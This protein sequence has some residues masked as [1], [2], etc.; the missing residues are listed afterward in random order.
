MTAYISV[1]DAQDY[2]DERLNTSAWD[3]HSVSGDNSQEKALKQATRIINRLNFIGDKTD[4]AQENQFPRGGD[5][6]IP[7]DIEI[8]C[9]EIAIALLDGV[10]PEIEL[11][12]LNMKTSAYGQTK[13]DYDRTNP[14][15]HIIAGVP[16]ATAWRYLKPYLRDSRLVA[17]TRV[18]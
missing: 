1:E 18:S 11:E 17:V 2:F 9:C 4:S 6:E 3:D 7:S 15:E 16:S 5:T 12:N 14:A 8:A 10:D 13:V